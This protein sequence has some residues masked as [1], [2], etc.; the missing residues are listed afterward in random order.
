MNSHWIIIYIYIY[1]SYWSIWDHT[2]KSCRMVGRI[3][4][5]FTSSVSDPPSSRTAS[6]QALLQD[7]AELSNEAGEGEGAVG[8][9]SVHV[10]QDALLLL[11]GPSVGR[12]LFMTSTSFKLH[13]TKLGSKTKYVR[14][15]IILVISYKLFAIIFQWF[16]CLESKWPKYLSSWWNLCSTGA[17]A[18]FQK[19]PCRPPSSP[20]A[21]AWP[22]PPTL[23]LV[24][25][26]SSL[27]TSS[28][29]WTR[30]KQQRKVSLNRWI[31][32]K[33]QTIFKESPGP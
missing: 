13:S 10:L 2:F 21:C 9:D 14:L 7:E 29:T 3:P 30:Q 18:L 25:I 28:P 15:K 8:V 22:K 11:L 19:H 16:E 20:S 32:G 23:G 27:V 26:G 33:V 17:W 6:A 12:R 1:I 31:K 5:C 24:V 4:K